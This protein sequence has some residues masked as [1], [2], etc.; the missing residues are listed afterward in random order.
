MPRRVSLLNIWLVFDQGEQKI[1]PHRLLTL[2][3]LALPRKDVT[4]PLL[5]A[6]ISRSPCC[7]SQLMTG[8]F[9]LSWLHLY[10][11]RDGSAGKLNP[12]SKIFEYLVRIRFEVLFTSFI[13][14]QKYATKL[15]IKRSF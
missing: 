10:E 13:T 15:N 2:S 7:Q 6:C 12:L 8:W 14:S 11:K 3:F 1:N 5:D 9:T 4:D